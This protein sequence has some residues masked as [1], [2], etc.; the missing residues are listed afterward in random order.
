MYFF[1]W[2]DERWERFKWWPRW[3]QCNRSADQSRNH[4]WW[5]TLFINPFHKYVWLTKKIWLRKKLEIPIPFETVLWTK[6]KKVIFGSRAQALVATQ[7]MN[8]SHRCVFQWRMNSSLPH[9]ESAFRITMG[10]IVCKQNGLFVGTLMNC[11]KSSCHCRFGKRGINA[12]LVKQ[13]RC[14]SDLY[15]Q[16]PSKWRKICAL[17]K[18]P[19]SIEMQKKRMALGR[20][21]RC[22]WEIRNENEIHFPTIRLHIQSFTFSTHNS[23]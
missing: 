14:R 18:M 15:D 1:S 8:V 3:S 16:N 20:T 13:A 19:N 17:R 7:Y 9:L 2:R 12:V 23:V 6:Q 22:N 21:E 11:V 10:Q 4:W 5:F